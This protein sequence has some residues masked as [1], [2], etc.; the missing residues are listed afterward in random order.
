[1]F[2]IKMDWVKALGSCSSS[3][4]GSGFS[5]VRGIGIES[6]PREERERA[7]VD[8]HACEFVFIM[9]YKNQGRGGKQEEAGTASYKHSRGAGTPGQAGRTYAGGLQ[10][11]LPKSSGRIR[12]VEAGCEPNMW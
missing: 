12:F 5:Y 1:M 10:L 11:Q 4:G 2:Y 7:R 9:A 3:S 6:G 8:Q